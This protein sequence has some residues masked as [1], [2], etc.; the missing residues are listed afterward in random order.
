MAALDHCSAQRVLLTHLASS[1][2]HSPST[3]LHIVGQVRVVL[4]RYRELQQHPQ[5][6]PERG[7]AGFELEQS[8]SIVC[9]GLPIIDIQ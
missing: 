7:R 1:T 9:T 8:G 2:S 4:H 3:N 5:G 6:H